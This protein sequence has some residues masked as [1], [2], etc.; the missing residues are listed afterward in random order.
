MQEVISIAASQSSGHLVT[1]LYNV[2]ESYIPYSRDAKLTHKNDVYLDPSKVNGKVNYYPRSLNIELS[3]GYGYLS[4]YAFQQA[5][6]DLSAFQNVKIEQKP[7]VRKNEYQ[8]RLDEG[9]ATDASMLDLENTQ[10]WTDYNRLIY[11]P[12]SLLT[13][14]DYKNP[15]GFHKHFE[16]LKFNTFNIGSAEYKQYEDQVDDAFRKLLE[17]SD[18]IQGINIFSELDNA[19]GGF[20]SEML[21]QLRDE[22]F[23][24]GVSSKYNIWCYGI[25]SPELPKSQTLT[26]IRSFIELS[27]SSSLLFPLGLDAS[28]SL[29]TDSFRNN[30]KWHREAVHA[31]FVNS[32]W[33]L[34]NRMKDGVSMAEMESHLLRGF[35]KRNIVNEIKI[36]E[37]PQKKAL[38]IIDD[39]R[40]IEAILRGE[41]MP[42]Q[43]PGELS[44]SLMPSAST[45]K[46]FFNQY[47]LP[48]DEE[49]ELCGKK[50]VN[51]DIQKICHV[52]SFPNIFTTDN[53]YTAFGQSTGLKDYLKVYRK[54]VQRTRFSK[55]IE[56]MGDK[57]ELIEDISNLVDEYTQGYDSDEESD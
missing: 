4:K 55:D 49:K 6:A 30:S 26:R 45:A 10:Y 1:H 34:C 47:I 44:L 33:S 43:K 5:E 27:K 19:W 18:N 36:H 39:P 22:Y 35:D 11:K 41:P 9:K 40:I 57:G 25:S 20:S 14:D 46:P 50:Y 48:A 53:L 38:D 32:I 2:Q 8:E 56:I 7:R 52:D 23:N 3:G 24:N 12:S 42:S 31:F 51:S 21:I 29:L 28:S 13:I 54:I 17:S 15:E 37:N 16:R